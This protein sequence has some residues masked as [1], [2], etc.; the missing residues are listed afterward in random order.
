[1]STNVLVEAKK[2]LTKHIINRLSPFFYEE[3]RNLHNKCITDCANNSNL[4]VVTEFSKRLKDI[5]E[6]NQNLID[7]FFDRLQ[8]TC[9]R[10]ILSNLIKSVWIANVQILSAIRINKNERETEVNVPDPKRFVHKC[11]IEGAREIYKNPYLFTPIQDHAQ[12]HRNQRDLLKLIS[13]ATKD[14]IRKMLPV[15]EIL[16]QYLVMGTNT[17]GPVATITPGD[18]NISDQDLKK[19]LTELDNMPP[20]TST[21][22]KDPDAIADNDEDEDEDEAFVPTTTTTTDSDKDVASDSEGHEDRN[23]NREDR[24]DRGDRVERHENSEK[25]DSSDD[26][27]RDHRDNDRDRD[28]DRDRDHHNRDRDRDRHDR[29][30]DRDDRDHRDHRDHRDRDHDNRDKKD[31]ERLRDIPNNIEVPLDDVRDNQKGGGGLFF[32]GVKDR[33]FR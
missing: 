28:R 30:Q 14:A 18:D 7:D 32:S 19:I 9:N 6:W 8:N 24:E 3:Y 2:E 16:K 27:D 12:Q 29:D 26:H 17:P 11:Y 4:D 15:E 33:R 21:A 25:R 1:M 31:R 13:V 10:D 23:R 5:P 20:T 22:A